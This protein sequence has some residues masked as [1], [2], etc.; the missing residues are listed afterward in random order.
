MKP[1]RKRGKP[2]GMSETEYLLASPA[3]AKRLLESIRALETGKGLI[4]RRSLGSKL[5]R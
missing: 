1:K 4:V 3:S 2:K 5:K